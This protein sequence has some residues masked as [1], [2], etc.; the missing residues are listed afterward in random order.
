MLTGFKRCS[1]VLAA[2]AVA[3]SSGVSEAQTGLA[4]PDFQ[5][6]KS[7]LVALAENGES[8]VPKIARALYDRH[9]LV[10]RVAV[11]LLG[12]R[13]GAPANDALETALRNFDGYV[14]KFALAGLEETGKVTL[15][16]LRAALD[17]RDAVVRAEAVRILGRI[18]PRTE[19]VTALLYRVGE[20]ETVPVREAFFEAM[21]GPEE[22]PGRIDP[23]RIEVT[24]TIQ[25]P[26]EGWRFRLDPEQVG[27][28]FGVGRGWYRE[29]HD[30]SDWEVVEIA[31][32]WQSF[33]HDYQGVGWYRLSFRLPEAARDAGTAI[34]FEGV[35]E[36]AWVWVNG[37]YVGSQDLGPAV[38]DVPFTLD[39]SSAVRLGEINH[40]AVRVKNTVKGGGIWRPMSVLFFH[41]APEGE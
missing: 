34:H 24:E 20:K 39:A 1:L 38:W 14:R 27:I 37:S 18:S 13:I 29:D 9:F 10:R 26:I 16:H 4:S 30:D 31:Q 33:G 3:A 5:E 15:Q 35:D 11:R 36:S 41:K 2:L 40:L 17:D 8:A 21:L 23:E 22:P 7:A 32:H 6:R 12:E 28:G 25:L 19:Q